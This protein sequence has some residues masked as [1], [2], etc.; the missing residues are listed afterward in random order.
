MGMNSLLEVISLALFG[1]KESSQG[2]DL[3]CNRLNQIGIQDGDEF[4]PYPDNL[5]GCADAIGSRR[6]KVRSH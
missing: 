2:I 3:N 1:V 6:T 4:N 5:D